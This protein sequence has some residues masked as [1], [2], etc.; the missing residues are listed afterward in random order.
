VGIQLLTSWIVARV[1][2]TL[3][4]RE[5]LINGEMRDETSETSSGLFQ[6]PAQDAPV[7]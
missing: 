2:E 5:D 3:A 1:L 4:E 7:I 6:G